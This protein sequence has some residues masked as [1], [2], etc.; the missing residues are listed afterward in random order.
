M[1]AVFGDEPVSQ[2]YWTVICMHFVED[3]VYKAQLLIRYELLGLASPLEDL[4]HKTVGPGL[5]DRLLPARY[6]IMKVCMETNTFLPLN[7]K[8]HVRNDELVLL[9]GS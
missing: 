6:R 1:S 3:T 4:P 8:W 5:P 9:Q 2:Y 7:W